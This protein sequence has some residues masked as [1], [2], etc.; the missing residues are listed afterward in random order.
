M[1]SS[2]RS[3]DY[4]DTRTVTHR[5]YALFSEVLAE[6]NRTRYH[7]G[8]WGSY[9]HVAT[10]SG[11]HR[12]VRFVADLCDLARFSPEGKVILDAG[13]GYGV[14]AI[15]LALMGANKVVG[16]DISEERLTTFAQ[17]IRDYGF[18]QQLEARLQ[19]VEDTSLPNASVDAVISNEAISH[20][21]DVD[22]FLRETA[23]VLKP[24]GVLLI[25]D[26]N[27]ACSPPS[28]PAHAGDL[29]AVRERPGGHGAWA[30]AGSS[31]H[32][33]ASADHPLGRPRPAG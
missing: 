9:G 22:A 8:L 16:V 3:K 29:G 10:P 25:S 26:G 30:R 5:L 2:K 21:Y 31:L 24:G 6:K 13:C 1:L 28:P 27:N 23:R 12:R 32:R 14:I 18:D 33:D 20:Y 4:L 15:I 17:I 11:A 7:E 19:R